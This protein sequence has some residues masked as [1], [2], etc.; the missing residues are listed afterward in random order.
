[1]KGYNQQRIRCNFLFTLLVSPIQGSFTIQL[2]TKY[3]AMIQIYSVFKPP[4]QLVPKLELQYQ[5]PKTTQNHVL[6]PKP[7]DSIPSQNFLPEH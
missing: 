4:K 6:R 2:D 7:L 3:T 1:M 5:G